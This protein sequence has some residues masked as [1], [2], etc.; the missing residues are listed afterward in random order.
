MAKIASVFQEKN[1][2]TMATHIHPK[3]ITKWIHYSKLQRNT[4]QYCDPKDESE[5]ECLAD[6][7]EADGEVLQNLLV[8]KSDADQYEIIAGHKRMYA[9]RLLVEKR[10]KEKYQL[11]PCTVQVI[12]EA[13]AKFQL[14]SS[15]Q[16]HVET[17]YE[18]MHKLEQMQYLLKTYPEEFP[19]LS[20]AKGRMVDKL[21]QMYHMSRTTVGEYLTISKN[22]S[23]EAMQAFQD[24]H[25]D[26]SA[27]VAM[28]SLSD[29]QQREIFGNGECTYKE[30]RQRKKEGADQ[31]PRM[32][33]EVFEHTNVPVTDTHVKQRP[34]DTKI[35]ISSE[36]NEIERIVDSGVCN[37]IICGYVKIVLDTLDITEAERD[38]GIYLLR[39][40][41]RDVSAAAARERWWLH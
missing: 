4:D 24:G 20:G 11:L 35:P 17:P 22:L 18:I 31:K 40:L 1:Q 21:A 2:E 12:S 7:I 3:R 16:H 23:D 33:Q 36:Q 30:I 26:K 13:K 32:R 37:D 25:L 27:A 41:F 28:A 34:N 8:R 38:N 19:E 14:Y 5:I 10:G 15:N 29:Q 6:M 9:C 39:T